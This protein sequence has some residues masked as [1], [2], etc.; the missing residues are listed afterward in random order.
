[1]DGEPLYEDHPVCFNAKDLGTSN[2]YDVRRYAYLD[3]FAGA[4]GHTYGCHDVWQ[5]HSPRH[6]GVNGPHLFWYD[7]LELPG[8]NQMIFVKK[9]MQSHPLLDR[10]P[11]QSLIVENNLASSERIQATR[12]TDYLFVYT[13]Q[14]KPFTVNLNKISGDRLQAY[15]YNP[16]TGESINNSVV[17]NKGIKRFKAPTSGYG[18]DWVLVMD[19]LAKRYPRL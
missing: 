18:Q 10:V 2:A 7:A 12:G 3:L 8:A 19:D 13:S 16:R 6:T 9:L 4:H 5:M 1:M 14:G 11:D 15:W 17:L